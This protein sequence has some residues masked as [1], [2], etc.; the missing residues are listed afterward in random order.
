MAN[1]DPAQGAC[2]NH[3]PAQHASKDHPAGEERMKVIEL[4]R[5]V[6]REQGRRQVV[7]HHFNQPVA[8][9]K[10]YGPQKQDPKGIGG[11]GKPVRGQEQ[12]HSAQVGDKGSL[13]GGFK[14]NLFQGRADQQ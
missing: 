8:Q 11:P 14:P 4:G 9:A 1:I 6:V 3:R 7:A 2:L 10:P 13:H 5:F 12:S